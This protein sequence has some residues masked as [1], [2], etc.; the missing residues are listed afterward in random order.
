M[1]SAA[2]TRAETKGD[3]SVEGYGRP[4]RS[5]SGR[6]P[7][8]EPNLPGGSL[9]SCQHRATLQNPRRRISGRENPPF[10]GSFPACRED[11]HPGIKRHPTRENYSS[12]TCKK[13]LKNQSRNWRACSRYSKSA[14]SSMGTS[15][16]AGI[17]TGRITPA[18]TYERWLPCWRANRKPAARN[19]FS[20]MRQWMGVI[21][22]MFR[23]SPL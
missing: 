10:Q 4:G 22:G 3:A 8:P 17:T 23:H 15:S 18:L 19:T 16:Y 2:P 5:T 20:K 21:L 13:T 14:I 9:Q 7:L 1:Q 11:P 6:L 12:F